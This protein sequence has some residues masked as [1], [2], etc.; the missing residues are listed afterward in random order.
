MIKRITKPIGNSL[1]TLDPNVLQGYFDTGFWMTKI[2]FTLVDS[3]GEYVVEPEN[4]QENFVKYTKILK[5]M[6]QGFEE[7]KTSKGKCIA[8][9]SQYGNTGLE[10]SRN[11]FP[12]MK[13]HH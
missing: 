11:V 8:V 2:S 1:I 13:Y 9:A 5:R 6:S 4:K 3:K 10:N 7:V 12:L